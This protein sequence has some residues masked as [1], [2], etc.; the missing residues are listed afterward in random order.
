MATLGYE[1]VAV[2]LTA[3]V[4]RSEP[5][6]YLRQTYEFGVLEDFDGRGQPRQGDSMLVTPKPG[7]PQPRWR[8]LLDTHSGGRGAAEQDR[9]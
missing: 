7:T 1:R 6:P 8:S 3:W 4:A 9:S 5:D 2:D